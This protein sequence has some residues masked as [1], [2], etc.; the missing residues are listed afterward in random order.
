MDFPERA[1]RKATRVYLETMV[2]LD[3]GEEKDQQESRER[4]VL[5]TARSSLSTASAALFQSVLTTPSSCGMV[6]ASYQPLS[7]PINNLSPVL[8]PV[9][10]DSLSSRPCYRE[11]LNH[12]GMQQM[13]WSL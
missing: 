8:V 1:V 7:A 12:V 9:C 5:A 13:M 2:S 10:S 3:I 11:D 4:E 6:T